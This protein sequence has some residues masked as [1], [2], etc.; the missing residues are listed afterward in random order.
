MN[1]NEPMTDNGALFLKIAASFHALT[2]EVQRLGK[3]IIELA[4]VQ[5]VG[6][7]DVG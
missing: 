7:G 4:K 2:D 1:D 6:D 3:L 5:E